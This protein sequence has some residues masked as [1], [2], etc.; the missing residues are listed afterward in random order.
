MSD[1]NFLSMNLIQRAIARTLL[2]AATKATPVA[3]DT[4]ADASFFGLD[5]LVS[6]RQTAAGI[7]VSRDVALRYAP[8]AAAVDVLSNAI[9]QLPAK[10]MRR[11]PEGGEE[12]AADHPAHQIVHDCWNSFTSATSGVQTL[13]QNALLDGDGVAIANRYPDG[14]VAELITLASDAFAIE[15][16]PVTGEPFLRLHIANGVTRVVDWGDVIHVP[17]RIRSCDGITGLAP[18]LLGREAIALGIVLDQTAA[19]IIANL[20][21]PGGILTL[22]GNVNADQVP[23]IRESWNDGF[24]GTNKGSIAVF[25]KGTEYVPVAAQALV[26]QQYLEQRAFQIQEIARLFNVP[27]SMLQD[28]SR[29]TWSN[30]AAAKEHFL[31][32]SLLPWLRS[33]SENFERVLLTE[34]ERPTYK[35]VHVVED[36]LRA[37]VASRATAYASFRSAG[38]YTANELRKL[39]GL[40]SLPEGDTLASP[41]TTSNTPAPT[42]EASDDGE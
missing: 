16:D 10:V 23:A 7:N 11:L 17:A 39:E 2:P 32:F 5:W 24:K 29:Q 25:G 30:A 15:R 27:V 6:A 42:E 9:A 18:I 12:V 38:I 3:P 4:K 35:I 14:R 31:Q 37:D 19:T 13:V 20:A 40:P 34:E 8:V 36:F 22:P 21:T 1:E 41:Y 28:Y 33:L 26:E